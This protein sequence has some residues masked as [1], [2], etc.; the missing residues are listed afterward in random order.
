[1]RRW[2][3]RWC[4][5]LAMMVVAMGA[6][7][8][9]V[10]GDADGDGRLS[11]KDALYVLRL[12]VG[13][14]IPDPPTTPPPDEAFGLRRLRP[15][16]TWEYAGWLQSTESQEESETI[17][18]VLQVRSE[19]FTSPQGD[20]LLWLEETT[21]RQ[22][23]GYE[24]VSS[25]GIL[26]GQDGT[27]SLWVY[28]R[29][30][31]GSGQPKPDWLVRPAR[32]YLRFPGYLDEHAAVPYTELQYASGVREAWWLSA[33]QRE[34]VFLLGK[35]QNALRVA[36]DTE[37][38]DERT[39]EESWFVPFLFASSERVFA[40][41]NVTMGYPVGIED[42]LVRMVLSSDPPPPPVPAEPAAQAQ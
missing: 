42:K 11:V 4:V 41:R 37:F 21:Y 31:P 15:G 33:K 18:R 12:L 29:M 28:G 10:T 24:Q 19:R 36:M 3:L 6:A 2:W 20:P 16:D 17:R 26:F 25:E 38:G 39:R 13:L 5:A 1:M 8:A 27:G 32:R 30:G 7:S 34:P 40:W 35:D 23:G 9:T 14:P 22:I